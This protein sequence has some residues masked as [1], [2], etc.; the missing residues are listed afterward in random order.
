MASDTAMGTTSGAEPSGAA[1]FEEGGPIRIGTRASPLAQAQAAETRARLMA[2]HALPETAFEMVVLSTR[3]DRILDRP[4]SEVGGKG[5][6]T[7]E[8]ERGLLEGSI[9]LA[10]HST[11]DVATELPDGLALAGFLPR[12]DARDAW[13]GREG[14]RLDTLPRGARV[15]TAS[16]RRRALIGRLRPDL[17]CTLFR[18]NVQT[19]LRKLSHGEADATLLARA[20]LERLAMTEVITETMDE[21]RFPPAP[22]QGVI[23]I[24]T[25]KGDDRVGRLLAPVRCR[26][27][28]AEV[29][30]ERAFLH[31]LDGSC[32]TPIAARARLAGAAIAFHGLVL[33]PDG[34]VVHESRGEGAAADAAL[35]GREAGERVRREAGEAFFAMLEAR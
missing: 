28:E 12:E 20:G 31:A 32:R 2:A 10:V 8:I 3:G 18:G 26:A 11:K 13:I 27:T 15:G 14:A 25:R 16:I 6:F 24:E 5:L 35:I 22:A 30:A 9:D 7:A 19:R 23:G 17:E 1:T 34:T 4:L 29:A 21:E 33:S